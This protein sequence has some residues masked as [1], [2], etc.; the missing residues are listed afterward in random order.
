MNYYTTYQ[1]NSLAS[2]KLTG[3]YILNQNI[4]SINEHFESFV[5]LIAALDSLPDIIV[6]T[7]TWLGEHDVNFCGFTANDV[8]LNPHQKSLMW[9]YC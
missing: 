6:L 8:D 1:F 5:E 9:I 4:R 3:L 2:D 7:E